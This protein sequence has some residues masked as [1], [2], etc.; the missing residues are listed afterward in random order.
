MDDRR[1]GFDRAWHHAPRHRFEPESVYFVTA[2][3]YER[4]LFFRDATR[5]DYLLR[6]L[7][8]QMKRFHWDL[9]A[10]AVMGNHYHFVAYCGE[11]PES[12]QAIIRAVH[13]IT[14]IYLNRLDRTAGRKVWFQYR[15]TCLTNERIY[16]ARLNY[17]HHNPVKHR[18]TDC[19]EDYSWCS[20][21]WLR[22]EATEE[23][24]RRVLSTPF[25]RVSVDDDY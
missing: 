9:Q 17:V 22:R 16:Y 1:V 24:V 14:A 10:W 11:K 25:D 15:D 6:I 3:T 18:L 19:A 13:S 8:E 4:H 7:F 5:L 23:Q 21:A 20:M 2:S 12:L